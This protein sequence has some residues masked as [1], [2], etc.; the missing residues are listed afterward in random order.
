[1]K[2]RAGGRPKGARFFARMRNTEPA[3]TQHPEAISKSRSCEILAAFSTETHP[4][5][6]CVLTLLAGTFIGW[7][8]TWR[9]RQLREPGLQ[10]DLV[11]AKTLA[12]KP[13]MK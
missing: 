4:I 6:T 9:S 1:M 13:F 11:G 12:P 2:H 7:V 8:R 3:S 5:T 10:L